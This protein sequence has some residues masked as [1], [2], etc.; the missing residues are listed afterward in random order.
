MR[1]PLRLS[2][3]LPLLAACGGPTEPG[4]PP[5]LLEALPRALTPAELRIV[6]RANA[7]AFD[8]LRE[9]AGALPPDSNLLLSPLSASMALGLAMAGPEGETFE[10]MRSG[11][12]F[13]GMTKSEIG[14]GYRGLIELLGGLDS[15]TEMTIANSIWVREGVTLEPAFV[16]AGR[17]YFDGEVATLD[18]AS[19]A[20]V[21]TINDWV[22]GQTGRKIARLLESRDDEGQEK[23][24]TCSLRLVERRHSCAAQRSDSC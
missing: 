19:P 4:V 11:L 1:V 24:S 22:G 14:E 6:D 5:P 17:D 10:A 23:L 18:F 13:E 20:A 2:L 12:R 3:A 8:L 15:R 7:F 21:E 16:G 9:V